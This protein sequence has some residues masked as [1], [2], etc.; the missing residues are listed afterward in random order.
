MFT[1]EEAH[2]LADLFDNNSGKDDM[3]GVANAIYKITT[4]LGHFCGLAT[5]FVVALMVKCKERQISSPTVGHPNYSRSVLSVGYAH[6]A[7]LFCYGVFWGT[8][9][10]STN[11]DFALG[12]Y[13]LVQF[14]HGIATPLIVVLACSHL[15]DGLRDMIRPIEEVA[16][17][18]V[19]ALSTV[20]DD[21]DEMS[22]NASR[23]DLETRSNKTLDDLDECLEVVD[24]GMA[25]I[26]TE[27]YA[28]I[29][30]PNSLLY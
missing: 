23:S 6:L 4:A 22:D 26:Y 16:S 9:Q 18:M 13:V 15:K 17:I 25:V 20:H 28:K 30:C 27:E 2:L 1:K 21:V 7:G 24:S 14:L 11:F 3:A 12:M 29:Q 8:Q 5:T 19:S 10:A